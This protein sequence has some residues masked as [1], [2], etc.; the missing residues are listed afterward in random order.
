MAELVVVRHGQASFGAGDAVGYDRLSDLGHAQSHAAGAHLRATGWLPDRVLGGT[1]TRHAET[2][3]G[4]GFDDDVERHAGFNEYDFHNLLAARFPAGVPAEV[5]QERKT[6]FRMLRETILDWQDGGLSRAAETF[7]AFEARVAGALAQATREG[8]RRVLVVSSGGVIGQLVA[9]VL[10]ASPR[11]MIDLNLQIKN[12]AI[13]R[14][15]FS[16]RRVMLTEFNATPHFD[17]APELL[18]YS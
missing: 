10:T 15:V 13:T 6:H 18:S 1:L 8:A 4:M 14:F 12:T 3:A 16:G 9:S 17:T 7:A 11:M 5:M 2:L